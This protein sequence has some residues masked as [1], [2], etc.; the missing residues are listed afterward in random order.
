MK[1]FNKILIANRGEIAVRIAKAAQK[2][3]IKTATIYAA[4][5]IAS[6]HVDFADEAY[7][8]SGETLGE[9]YL[10]IAQIVDIAV[11]TGCEAIHPGYGF[12][13]ENPAFVKACETAG[14][15]FIGPSAEAMQLMGNKI[16]AR[17]FAI[18]N[19]IPV[20]QGVTGDFQTIAE[21]VKE[22]P[23][24]VLIKA[25]AGGG[26]K[27]MRVVYEEKNL[28]SALEATAREA[29]SYFGDDAVFVE[30]YVEQPRHIEV[31]V[32]AD[33]FGNVAHLFE[34]ECS[35][36]RR[37]QK[38]IEEAPSPT[39]NA[40]VR[41]KITETAKHLTS[42][43]NYKNAGT[44]E[45]LVDKDLN[46]YF[47]EMNTRVQV[48]HPVTE[49][50]TGVDI[51]AEQLS[52]AAGNELSFAQEDIKINGHSIECRIYAEDP[53]NDYMPAP[54]QMT[55]YKHF[56]TD[57]IR[58]DTGVVPNSEIKSSYDPMI[59]K[60]IVHS[61]N[62]DAAI[63]KMNIALNSFV[64]QGIK[65]NISFLKQLINTPYFIGNEISVKF[66]DE[67]T[68]IVIDAIKES[69]SKIDKI[70]P[71]VAYAL[72]STNQEK[73]GNV[74][75]QIGFWRNSG[76]VASF[77]FCE[78]NYEVE[79]LDKKETSI[80]LLVNNEPY[81]I[82]GRF[83]STNEIRFKINENYYDAYC[84]TDKKENGFVTINT[85]TFNI[86]RKDVLPEE[87]SVSELIESSGIVSN[88]V[89]APMPGRIVDVLVE[90]GQE[91]KKG[92]VLV[93][94]ESMKM[95]NQILSPKDGV[96]KEIFVGKTDMVDG[97]KTLVEL[98]E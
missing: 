83:N 5:D 47:L 51:V 6:K 35:V 19:N 81:Q 57:G 43:I 16:E 14:L 7:L 32:I 66:C 61:E 74:W 85:N 86:K 75:Q 18:E 22:I 56:E 48:E 84:S 80:K 90:A 28:M 15:V 70:V 98:E 94:L 63:G 10:N 20:I 62:R 3:G 45:F 68:D 87:M 24:P 2:L 93:I 59:A 44:I 21:K 92:D 73:N 52:I 8:L 31:Q 17:K 26:G 12:L 67:K 13:A 77:E 55:F 39:L 11:K 36:Q 50:I 25:A 46:F 42:K 95:E 97:S 53:E 40:K 27:G 54:G 72:F 65:N 60:L 38:I 71:V 82:C 79:F 76:T 96:I 88:S 49:M 9:T 58:V 34:R 78:E 4:D 64:V 91:V 89:K 37:H 29:K 23:F 30:K 33:G 1:K 41:A 69:K